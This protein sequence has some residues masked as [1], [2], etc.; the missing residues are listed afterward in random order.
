MTAASTRADRARPVP[1]RPVRQIT[2]ADQAASA[3]ASSAKSS[4]NPSTAS[5]ARGST[6]PLR[7]IRTAMTASRPPK[8]AQER[9]P[10]A[11][12]A[13]GSG[14]SRRLSMGRRRGARA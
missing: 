7:P 13:K 8:S 3:T 5:E 11:E 1:R 2:P 12:A 14:A 4:P 10:V 9:L 6:P